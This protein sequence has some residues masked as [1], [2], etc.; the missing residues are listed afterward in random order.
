VFL[1]AEVCKLL[2]VFRCLDR[3]G[4]CDETDRDGVKIMGMRR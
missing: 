3:A 1:A 2:R 4:L